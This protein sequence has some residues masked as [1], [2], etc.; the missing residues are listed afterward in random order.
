LLASSLRVEDPQHVPMQKLTLLSKLLITGILIGSGITAYHTYGGMLQASAEPPQPKAHIAPAAASAE[1]VSP[2]AA[3]PSAKPAALKDRPIRVA[4]SQWPGHMALVV[5]AGG[6]R[7]QPGSLAAREGLDLEIVFIEDAPSKNLALQS[8]DVDFAWQTIDELP[9]AMSGYRAK[10]VE[11]AT[12]L[13]LDWSRGGDACVA[14]KEVQQVEDILGRKSAV[15]MFSPDHTLFEFLITNSRLSREQVT[16][17]RKATKFSPDDI[18]FAR[19]LFAKNEVDV[20][21]L[22]EPDVSLALASRPGA[23]L[24]FSTADATELVADVLLSRKSF[25][26]AHQDVAE[27][28]ARSWFAGVTEGNRDRAAAAKLISTV[29]SRFKDE[30]GY[31]KTLAALTWAKWTTLADNVKLFG[32]DGGAPAFDRVYNQADG[33]WINYPQAEIKDRFVP[34]VLRDAR[35]VKAVWEAAGKPVAKV[36]EAFRQDEARTG[37]ALFTKPVSIGFDSGSNQLS[38]EA[39]SLLN[40][41]VLPQLQIAGGMYARVEGNT[42]SIGD[43]STNQALS[44]RRAAAIVAYLVGRGIPAERLVARG[45]GSTAPVA[46]NRTPDGRAQNRRTDVLFIRRSK[47]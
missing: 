23:H 21:C 35:A 45:N 1:P 40:Q 32:L 11:A 18:T 17:V 8:G 29:A 12:V 25:L 36:D 22:W 27:K 3:A 47:A 30:L 28:L 6:L 7:T 10:N 9:I 42:D 38:A 4:L 14:T 37:A 46:S 43:A 39:I 26:D 24:L 20:A 44:E 5:A 15:M 31:E 16:E 41:Q 13:Q 2:T 19:Q 34:A 33:I